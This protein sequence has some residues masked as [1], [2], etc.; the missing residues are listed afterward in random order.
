[1]IAKKKPL[2]NKRRMATNWTT[3]YLFCH[4]FKSI[5]EHG[6]TGKKCKIVQNGKKHCVVYTNGEYIKLKHKTGEETLWQFDD[7]EK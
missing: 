7:C 1:M 4:T 3:N 5:I 2:V 6:K